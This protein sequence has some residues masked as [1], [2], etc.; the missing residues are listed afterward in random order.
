MLLNLSNREGHKEVEDDSDDE[1]NNNDQDEDDQ[2]DDFDNQDDQDYQRPA[3]KNK[4]KE[5]VYYDRQGFKM[6]Q[7]THDGAI[8][9][10]NKE[11][12]EKTGFIKKKENGDGRRY[13]QRQ[14]QINFNGTTYSPPIQNSY[15]SRHLNDQ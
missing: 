1:Y 6:E 4:K 10:G 11:F 12:M 14:E 15:E 9:K 7:Y 13:G 8:E 5:D 2:N 3:R